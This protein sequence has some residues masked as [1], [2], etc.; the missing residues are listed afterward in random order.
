M[1]E[2]LGLEQPSS[3]SAPKEVEDE[4]DPF[5]YKSFMKMAGQDPEGGPG[6][7]PDF[8]GM[9]LDDS[10]DANDLDGANVAGESAPADA[11]SNAAHDEL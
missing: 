11:A 1:R 5:D 9:N 7:M 6:G 2:R 4:A 8:D 3:E 10:V